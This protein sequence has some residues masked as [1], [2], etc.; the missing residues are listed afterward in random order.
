MSARLRELE[1]LAGG[2]QEADFDLLTPVCTFETFWCF[3]TCFL[4]PRKVRT[5]Y[6]DCPLSCEVVF[7]LTDEE[8]AA[9]AVDSE[10]DS[11]V[12]GAAA[13]SVAVGSGVFEAERR[14]KF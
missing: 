12:V 9:S 6:L 14:G 4:F 11:V 1:P 2:S 7:L 3:M 8:D 10:I 5:S 13:A